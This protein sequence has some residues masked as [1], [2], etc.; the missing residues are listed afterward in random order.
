MAGESYI[1]MRKDTPITAILIYDNGEMARF[2]DKIKYPELMPL[3]GLQDP[4]TCLKE[5]WKSRSIPITQ[6]NVK[7]ILEQMG[8]ALSEEYLSKNL[9]LSLTDY[10]WIK[11]IDSP[12]TW[13]EV[14]LFENDFKENLVLFQEDADTPR[15]PG[16]SPN[17]SLQ[18]QLEKTWTIADGKRCMIKGNH[19]ELSSESINEVIAATIHELQGHEH[20]EYSLINISGKEYDYG[21]ISPLF[22]SLDDELVSAYALYSSCKKK[23]DISRY[24]HFIN[25][26]TEHGMEPGY[27]RRGLDYQIMTDFIISGFD[28]HLN[29]IAFIRDADTLKFKGFAPIYDCGGAFYVNQ[30][31]PETLRELKGLKTNG[32][33][34]KESMLIK[35]VSDYNVIDLT[36]LPPASYIKEMYGKDSHASKKL[37]DTVGWIYEAKIDMCRALQLG[38]DPYSIK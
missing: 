14:N 34:S 25:V 18:G 20:A 15:T 37:I 23:N 36:K 22:T 9:G 31:L 29:N 5:W 6:G 17:S 12:L 28:R 4:Q 21:C 8:Y 1:L 10:Y 16:Y 32:F 11:P 2:S 7:R 33:N 30:R 24:E 3:E 38:K 26:C 35:N 27:V 19:S 13:K